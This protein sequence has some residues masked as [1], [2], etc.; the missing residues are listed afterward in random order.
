MSRKKIGFFGGCFNP[1]SNIHINL[2]NRLIEEQK[3]DKIVFVPVNDF[4]KKN[5]LIEFKH[6]FTMLK[7][8]IEGNSNLEVDDFEFKENR[9]LYAIDVFKIIEEKYSNYDIYFI[10]GSD[11]YSKL[12][13]W[14]EYE[15]LKKYKY[16]VLDR[17]D[18]DISSTKIRNMIKKNSLKDDIL[19]KKVYEYIKKNKLYL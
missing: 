9:K 11:N 13:K 1:P 16:I 5:D 18:N 12:Q 19:N 4:Y 15:S 6:R 17:N 2:A 10:M 3:L 8:A 14:K 7:F